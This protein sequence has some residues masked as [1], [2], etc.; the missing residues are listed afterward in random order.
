MG[1]KKPEFLRRQ[2]MF[3][4]HVCAKKIFYF[5]SITSFREI[6]NVACSGGCWL[7]KSWIKG[8]CAEFV[9]SAGFLRRCRCSYFTRGF[10]ETNPVVNERA[11]IINARG[12]HGIRLRVSIDE[13]EIDRN[14]QT[15]CT[16]RQVISAPRRSG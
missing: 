9:D 1:R 7:N 6:V 8:V 10:G 15:I 12:R 5:Y 14:L 3:R 16:N 13:R 4:V 2:C 11:E